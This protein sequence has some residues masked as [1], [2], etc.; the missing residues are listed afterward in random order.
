VAI[1]RGDEAYLR[2]GPGLSAELATHR[3]MARRAFPVAAILEHGYRG[4]LPYYVEQSLGSSTLGD[5]FDAEVDTR[6]S[7]SDES[8][9]QFTEVISRHARAQ[10]RMATARW[11][12]GAFAE[13]IGVARAAALHPDLAEDMRDAFEDAIGRL[14]RFRGTLLHGDL[15]SD[16]TC[17]GGV[18]DLEGAG[19]GVIGYDVVTAVFVSAMAQAVPEGGA[20]PYAGFSSAQL[21]SY[22][23]LL[24]D[25]FGARGPGPVSDELEALLLCR[26]ISMCSRRHRDPAIWPIRTRLLSTTLDTV[27]R[28][29][30]LAARWGLDTP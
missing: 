30:R 9:E 17:V 8:F 20:P 28:G 15:H 16:N 23:S 13:F 2:I 21:R 27:R 10:A 29:G 18:I 11:S 24:D 12:V 26:A 14:Q 22:L 5:I 7:V 25:I 19:R 6:G 3:Q 4:R 1:Y